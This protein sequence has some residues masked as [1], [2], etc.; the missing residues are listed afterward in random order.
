MFPIL[1]QIILD[2]EIVIQSSEFLPRIIKHRFAR[3]LRM[4]VWVTMLRAVLETV[5]YILVSFCEI[6][7]Q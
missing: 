5:P 2:P 6:R 4:R 3:I 7:A 1:S